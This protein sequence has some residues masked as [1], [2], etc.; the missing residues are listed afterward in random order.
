MPGDVGEIKQPSVSC[1]LCELCDD[2]TS[3]Q[4]TQGH[5]FFRLRH[6]RLRST[7]GRK[8]SSEPSGH[9]VYVLRENHAV[10]GFSHIE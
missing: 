2:N 8:I 9:R 6:V 5:A 7:Y 3:L 1:F 4:Q 10:H